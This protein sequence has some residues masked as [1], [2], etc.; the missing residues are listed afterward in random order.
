MVVGWPTKFQDVTDEADS[1]GGCLAR[2]NI[3]TLAQLNC[4][5][6]NLHVCLGFSSPEFSW[7]A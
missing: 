7:L 2:S 6:T 1:P 5:T 3:P 4:D